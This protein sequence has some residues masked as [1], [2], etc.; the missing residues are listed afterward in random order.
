MGRMLAKTKR[1]GQCP[2]PG[3]G[4]NCC[5]AEEI[6]SVP[7]T[8]TKDKRATSDFIQ[9]ELDEMDDEKNEENA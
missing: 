7:W 6:Q 5:V 1:N 2:V 4:A 3:H 8:R 9:H